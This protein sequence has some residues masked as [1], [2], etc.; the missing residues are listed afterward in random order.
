MLPKMLHWHATM[1]RGHWIDILWYLPFLH[2]TKMVFCCYNILQCQR[3]CQV[4]YS[5]STNSA[6]KQTDFPK[7]ISSLALQCH[8]WWKFDYHMTPCTWAMASMLHRPCSTTQPLHWP[9]HLS[10][11]LSC[12]VQYEPRNLPQTKD[13]LLLLPKHLDNWRFQMWCSLLLRC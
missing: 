4:T 8:V 2:E 3:N 11:L 12:I 6:P 5:P 9:R 7:S 13:P 1:F 10:N